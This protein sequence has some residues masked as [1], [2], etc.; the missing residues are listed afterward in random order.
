MNEEQICTILEIEADA[1]SCM[2]MSEPPKLYI[3]EFERTCSELG[4][5]PINVS[6]HLARV[7]ER[8]G[9]IDHAKEWFVYYAINASDPDTL[10]NFFLRNCL[11][12]EYRK[13]IQPHRR[14]EEIG[15]LERRLMLYRKR[16]AIAR[17]ANE[18]SLQNVFTLCES[19]KY[20][21]G[22]YSAFRCALRLGFFGG[23]DTIAFRLG[24]RISPDQQLA[25]IRSAIRSKS[26]W[27]SHLLL[28]HIA[29]TESY[30][31]QFGNQIIQD[32]VDAA[33]APRKTIVQF[34]EAFQVELT[35]QQ[36]LALLKRA[37]EDLDDR[38]I[39][40]LIIADGIIRDKP[41]SKRR[42]CKV[43]QDFRMRLLLAES[44]SLHDIRLC[45]EWLGTPLTH[46]QLMSFARE[47]FSNHDAGDEINEC[48][49][50][51]L[52]LAASQI[53]AS[54]PRRSS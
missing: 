54:L 32:A 35:I 11:V 41:S 28:G 13:C 19:I 33:L 22:M 18:D 2:V 1:R 23:A 31:L 38:T 34:A 51:A 5:D 25:M 46:K 37:V 44:A 50:R 42:V 20:K 8:E 9:K 6:L 21:D 48:A 52:Q 24:R 30:R 47:I 43:I 4:I 3:R 10:R 16:D 26:I 27:T 53:H 15:M 45:S 17:G 39:C 12:E 29:N 40:I 7:R 14:L 49:L 36:R